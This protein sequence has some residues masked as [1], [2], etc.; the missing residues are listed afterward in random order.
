METNDE[1]PHLN[2][3]V[4]EISN[5]SATQSKGVYC[6]ECMIVYIFNRISTNGS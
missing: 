3:S 2:E 4:E 5:E 6:N 1:T